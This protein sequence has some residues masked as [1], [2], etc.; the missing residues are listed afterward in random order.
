MNK[1]SVKIDYATEAVRLQCTDGSFDNVCNG[2]KITFV[3]LCDSSVTATVLVNGATLA[4][5]NGEYTV[6]AGENTVIRVNASGICAGQNH[7][8]GVGLFGEDLTAYNSNV[9]MAPIWQGNT[10][11]HEAVMFAHSADGIVQKEKRLLY[12]IDEVISVRSATL[13]KWYV[14]G[15]DYTVRDGKLI[16]LEGGDCPC[17]KGNF[18]VPINTADSYIDPA[19]NTGTSPNAA[20]WYRTQEDGDTGLNLIYDAYHEK[21]TLY[22]T[23]THSKTWADL[24]QQGYNAKAPE[25]MSKK[26][27]YLYEKLESGSDINVLVYGAST[28]TGC[29]ATGMLMN[30]DLFSREPDENGDYKVTVRN[31][32]V[33]GI[34]APT[35]FEQATNELVAKF[36]K[37]NTVNYYNI[38]NGGTGAAWGLKSLDSRVAFMDKYYGTH[39]V[40]DVIYLKFMG[41]DVR[42]APQSFADSIEGMVKRFKEL[43]PQALIVLVGGKVNNERCYIHRNYAQNVLVQQAI[44]CDLSEKYENCVA[45][46][47]TDVWRSIVLCKDYEDYLSNNINHANDFWVKITAQ[48]IFATIAKQ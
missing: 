12:P 18:I 34:A 25:N 27:K 14:Y 15:V 47:A 6:T 3:A 39:I 24:G 42:T 36:G 26:V 22:V 33:S 28:A 32:N 41:N 45:V 23:Y 17:W 4:P 7:S 31:S 21:C 48:L 13:D 16:F 20:S 5:V 29:S 35:F 37:N 8:V 44:L 38:A 11:Y 40:P 2:D 46:K 10:V 30:Y 1:F 19:L 43:Y 9:F